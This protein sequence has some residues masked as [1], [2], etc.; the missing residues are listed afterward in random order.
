MGIDASYY[1]ILGDIA[2]IESPYLRIRDMM[3]TKIGTSYEYRYKL[4]ILINNNVVHT[5]H[6]FFS[7]AEIIDKNCWN[8]A[9]TN[10]KEELTKKQITFTDKI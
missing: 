2:K 9:Y 6:N 10:I 5:E 4:E 3:F 8:V 7:M 1:N